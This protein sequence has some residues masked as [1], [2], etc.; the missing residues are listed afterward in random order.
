M[1]I[2]LSRGG[3]SKYCSSNRIASL[4]GNG[5]PTLIDEKVKY[6]DFFN[7]NE[8]ITYKNIDDLI[9][10]IKFYKSKS[11]LLKK[12]GTNAK[13]KYFYL[14]NNNIIAD[15]IISKTMNVK[16]KFKKR[17]WIK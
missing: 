13:R 9:K 14:F 16:L 10:K 3:P 15:Y 8:I 1:A 12:I 11:K 7:K 4:M 2:N 6:Q 5:V 17:L